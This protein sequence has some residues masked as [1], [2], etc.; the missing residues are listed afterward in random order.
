[1]KLIVDGGEPPLDTSSEQSDDSEL[2]INKLVSKSLW[3]LLKNEVQYFRTLRSDLI[4]SI[5]CSLTNI[6]YSRKIDEVGQAILHNRCQSIGRKC[7]P[8]PTCRSHLKQSALHYN[9][10]ANCLNE[11]LTSPTGSKSIKKY[12]IRWQ[13]WTCSLT[14]SLYWDTTFWVWAWMSV[15][16]C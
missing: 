6:I 11:P 14:L 10:T 5:N 7:H 4:R 12:H 2:E 3:L 8:Q 13:H 16:K 1:M 15:S 9:G